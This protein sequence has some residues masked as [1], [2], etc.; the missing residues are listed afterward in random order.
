MDIYEYAMKLEKDGE[1]YYRELVI[2]VD[3][4]GLKTILTMLADAEVRH[5]NTFRSMKNNEPVS[6]P[7]T[8]PLLTEVK[9]IFVRMK[10]EEKA[11]TENA[12]DIDL[13][14][15]AQDI[16]KKT[17]E[18]YTE[19]SAEV[20]AAQKP[21]FLKI[22]DEERKHYL[23]LENII[24]FVSRPFEWLENAEWYHLEEY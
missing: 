2:K 20:P 4:P 1:G 9:N 14:R 8:T 6:V 22:A 18:F 21:I 12:S 3:N 7:D 16:E 5:Y 24:N 11:I 15:K 13:Y 10:E 17:E 19:K 23:I